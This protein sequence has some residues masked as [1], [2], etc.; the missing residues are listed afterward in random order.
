ML[1][2]A[3]E[4]LLLALEDDR[5]TIPSSAKEPLTYGLPAAGL[6]ELLLA[7]RLTVG[8]KKKVAVVDGSLT[9]DEI[10]D[11]MLSRIQ[12]AR[13]PKTLGDWVKDFGSGIKRQRERLASRLA[14]RGI[15]RVEEGSHLGIF[16]WR[17]YPTVGGA[18]EA[19]T[20]EKLRR[21]L[22]EGEDPDGRTAI[23][24]G[25]VKACKLLDKLY[26]KEQRKR[27]EARAKEIAA[28]QFADQAISKAVAEA[29][30]ATAAMIA[31]TSASVSSSSN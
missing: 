27:V 21:V 1:S 2:I 25:L 19:G 28:G 29:A 12:K 22:L 9:G 23:L 4:L 17:R 14:E 10:H 13:K 24:I 26:P 31:I 18:A 3:E 8:E 30:A 7:G 15:L 16:P 5:G 11:E 6:S 20:R